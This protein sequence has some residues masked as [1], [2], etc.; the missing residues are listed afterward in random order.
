[1]FLVNM[2]AVPGNG[3]TGTNGKGYAIVITGDT[4]RFAIDDQLN[5][6]EVS[7]G[8]MRNIL[9]Y[10]WTHIAAVRDTE[11]GMLKLYVN[12]KMESGDPDIT[13]NISQEGDVYFGNN[14]AASGPFFGILDDI[15]I[16]N[17]ALSNGE[18]RALSGLTSVV[19]DETE[20][21]FSHVQNYPN[22][23]SS[24]TTFSYHLD[25]DE[26]VR[27]CIYNAGGRLIKTILNQKQGAGEHQLNFDAGELEG[28]LYIYEL[29]IGT[30]RY[31]GKMILLK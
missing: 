16:F 2:G 18:V 15:Q 10:H 19:P 26:Q 17:Y 25:S 14:S 4:L 8:G 30:Q 28:G 6:S 9:P 23:F 27:L 24:A 3:K 20:T 31:H 11:E 29:S 1:M 22:P 21:E 7:I 5:Q 13:G 12:G